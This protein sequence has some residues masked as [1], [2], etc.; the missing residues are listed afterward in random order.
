MTE[1]FGFLLEEGIA[2][3]YLTKMPVYLFTLHSYRSWNPDNPRGFV[4]RGEGV[5]PTDDGMALAYA[6]AASEPP[7]L[8]GDCE[9]SVLHWIVWDLCQRR[10]W[11]LHTIAFDPSHV[12][13]LLSWRDETPMPQV[14]RKTKNLM[15]RELGLRCRPKRK[16]WFGKFGSKQRVRE[17]AHFD[18]LINSYFPRHRGLVWREG[19]SPPE[20]PSTPVDG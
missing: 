10:A 14:F 7:F 2:C 11:R 18:H 6:N 16:H 3:D 19:D 5:R 1:V 20:E 15:S 12:H 4:R 13:I 17:Q 9:Q 8:F